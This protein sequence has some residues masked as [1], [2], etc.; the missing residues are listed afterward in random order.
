MEVCASDYFWD[1]SGLNGIVVLALVLYHMILLI[2]LASLYFK[3]LSVSDAIHTLMSMYRTRTAAKVV[4]LP[5]AECELTS[6]VIISG[7][8]C[9]CLQTH[10]FQARS[11]LLLQG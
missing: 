9:T 7:V 4:V 1:F 8:V 6:P 11:C 5:K 2:S 10:K 3:K